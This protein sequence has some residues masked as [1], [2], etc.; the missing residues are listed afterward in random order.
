MKPDMMDILFKMA[1][2][3]GQMPKAKIAAAIMDRKKVLGFGFNSLKSDPLQAKYSKNEH[4]I[5][6]HAEIHAIKNAIRNHGLDALEGATMYVC[7]VKLPAARATKYVTAMAEP[8][9]G[10]KRAI[11][12]FGIKCVHYTT[13]PYDLTGKYLDY[14][15]TRTLPDDYY[16]KT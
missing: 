16:L 15:A 11:S 1:Q 8:C 14:I 7:R 4:A 10:C 3:N 9:T 2:A 12:A 5:Y 6:F 13:E